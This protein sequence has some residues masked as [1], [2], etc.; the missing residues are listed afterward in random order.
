M[1]TFSNQKTAL[2]TGAGG[3]LGRRVKAAFE[4]R[5]W[6]VVELTRNPK[7]GSDAARFQL[8]EEVS[9]KILAGAKALVHCAYDFKPLSWADIHRVNVEGSEKLLRAAR[10]ARI[11]KVI[12]ISSISAFGECRSRYGKAKLETEKIAR[13]LGVFVLRPGLIYGDPPDG[14]FGKLIE[15]VKKARVLPLFGGGSQIQYL[16]HEADL[17]AVICDCA[18][19]KFSPPETPVTIAHEQPWTFRQILETIARAKGKKLSFI[20]VPWRLVWAA[21][22]CAELCRVPLNFRSD[23]LVSLIY[24]DPKPSF[25]EQRGLKIA[26]RRFVFKSD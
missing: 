11:E 3:Y 1:P 10:P 7:S 12:Y 2:V 17:C 24:Q 23:S 16:V 21:I 15:Q 19:E 22:K 14:M 20:P 25:A 4:Q 6:R 8:G 5:G 9:P 13:S 26:C 18:E